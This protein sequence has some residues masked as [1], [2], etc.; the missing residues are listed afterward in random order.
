MG[1]D[2]SPHRSFS[3]PPAARMRNAYCQKRLAD[4]GKEQ[5]PKYANDYLSFL[6]T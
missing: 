2:V 1:E 3:T 6:E 5:A 4:Y